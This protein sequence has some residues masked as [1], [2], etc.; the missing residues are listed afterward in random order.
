MNSFKVADQYINPVKSASEVV[1]GDNAEIVVLFYDGSI[2]V[3]VMG[4]ISFSQEIKALSVDKPQNRFYTLD[5]TTK[6]IHIFDITNAISMNFI[7]SEPIYDIPATALLM[8]LKIN[9]YSKMVSVLT[10]N[11][12]QLIIF[13]FL[14]T[15]VAQ[16][17]TI[18]LASEPKDM[19]VFEAYPYSVVSLANG[20]VQAW[21]HLTGYKVYQSSDGGSSFAVDLNSMSDSLMFIGRDDGTV[22]FYKGKPEGCDQYS[23]K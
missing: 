22:T 20:E 6:K 12:H 3:L 15:E 10:S 4:T 17:R 9:L 16:F 2:N 8:D 1:L 14:D 18:P 19:G 21:D 7:K 11:P 13:D 23:E 5:Q